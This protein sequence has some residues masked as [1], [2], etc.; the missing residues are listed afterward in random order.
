[1]ESNIKYD[2]TNEVFADVNKGVSTITDNLI[3][4]SGRLQLNT[5]QAFITN[6]MNPRSDLRALLLVHMTGTGKTITAL[7]TATEYV[8]Q[9]RENSK[10][11][12]SIVV[13]GFTKDIFKKELLSHPEFSFVS[14]DE[15]KS[16]KS[17]EKYSLDSAAM[18]EQYLLKKRKYLRRITRK[19][20]HG[21]YEF[22]GYREFANKIIN[23]EDLQRLVKDNNQSDDGLLDINSKVI[24]SWIESGKVRINTEFIRRFARSLFI[25]D[26]VHN[27]Y[28]HDELNTYGLAI[29][30]TIQYFYETLPENDMDY[31]S[32]RLLLLSATPLTS[33]ATEA[34]PLIALLTGKA[35]TVDKVFVNK[36]GVDQLTSAGSSLIRQSLYGRI[37]Y[38]M[39][40]NPKEYPSSSFEGETITGINYLRFIQTHPIKFQLNGIKKWTTKDSSPSI[41]RGS[42]M[43]KDI[44]LPATNDQPDGVV[45]SRHINELSNLSENEAVYKGDDG[46]MS[47]NLFIYNNL[48]QY[49]C[50]YA[51][52]IKMCLS[53]KG[54]EHGKIFIYHPFVQGSGTDMIVSILLANGFIMYG[55]QPQRD[56][57][58]M[59]CDV[60]YGSHK[61]KDHEFCSV[62]FIYINGTIAKSTVASRLDAYNSVQN[63]YGERVKIIVGS[64]AMRESH[65]LKTCRHVF[66]THEPSSLSEMIQ[67]IGRAVRKHVHSDLPPEMRMVKIHILTTCLDA[68]ATA[69]SQ[70]AINEELSYRYKVLQYEQ[71]NFIE[72]IMYDVSIDYL[73]NFRFKLRETPPLLGS[74]YPL[75]NELYTEYENDMRSIYENLR[76]GYSLTGIHTTRFNVFY[77]EGEVRLVIHIIK[78]IV[79]DHQPVIKISQLRDMIRE[80]PFHVEYNTKLISDESISCAIYKVTFKSDQLRIVSSNV[81]VSMVDSLYDQSPKILDRYGNEYYIICEGDPL[82][83]DSYLIRKDAYSLM[84]SESTIINSFRQRYTINLD[85]KIDLKELSDKWSTMIDVTEIINDIKTQ[86][87]STTVTDKTLS[88]LP[89]NVHAQVAE[90][91]IQTAAE[92]VF[93]NKKI[94]LF[95]M[96]RYIIEYYQSRGFIFTIADLHDTI[97]QSKYKKYNTISSS[98]WFSKTT[99]PSL[100]AFPIAHFIDDSI[101]IYQPDETAWLQLNSVKPNDNVKYLYDFYIYEEKNGMS[102]V[103]KVKFLNDEKSKGITMA[104]LQRPDLIDIAKKLKVK[105]IES[106]K[107]QD[108]IN[109][110]IESAKAIQQKQNPKRI[111]YRLIDI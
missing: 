46:I 54:K 21:I 80:P 100:S 27:L 28:K 101:K 79:M 61:N 88:K 65:T 44:I 111:F 110:I 52:L 78:R 105:F 24:K 58:C 67:I 10:T 107:K 90:W 92:Y 72:R 59:N 17:L 16:L 39:D 23:I 4:E 108:I 57:I 41:D 30:Y 14:M 55:E 73:I 13:L 38:I 11:V 9:H 19:E 33:S 25:C 31:A 34:L 91:A 64:K 22:Y 83:L 93:K 37:S 43:I 84:D 45:F 49:S 102:I 53:M 81:S 62:Q 36:D 106:D 1:M 89:I 87:P 51:T 66:I 7:S 35:Y 76:K 85:V 3:H 98:S 5:Y 99:K 71:I 95:D 32:V 40:D 82:C 74:A 2:K 86:W 50:K 109:G 94:S 96:V 70:S 97:L 6:V 18:N 104:F 63:V 15:V 48:V 56:S 8:R 29:Y 42:N 75:N 103:H 69:Q 26:E 12:S 47:S 77:F 20:V 60:K 68:I